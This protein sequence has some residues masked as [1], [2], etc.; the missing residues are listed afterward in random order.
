MHFSDCIVLSH[1]ATPNESPVKEAL[2]IL[3]ASHMLLEPPALTAE[4]S[5]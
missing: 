4:N 5:Y 1:V 3:R 2:W